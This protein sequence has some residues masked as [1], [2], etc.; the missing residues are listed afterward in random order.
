MKTA[1]VI[2]EQKLRKNL[3]L[4]QY[5]RKEA[6]V[7][8]LVALK[9]MAFWHYFPLMK[10]YLSGACASSLNEV[11]LIYEEMGEK[12]HTYCPVFH[13]EEFEEICR[14]SS[15]I[16]FNSLSQWEKYK[17]RVPEGLSLGLRINPGYSEVE[18]DLYNPARPGSRLGIIAEQLPETLPDGIKGLHFHVLCEQDS[19][20]LERVLKVVEE[21]F[22]EH[23]KQVKWINMGGGHHITRSDYDVE[24]LI[25][26]LKDFKTRYPHLQVVLE[27]GEAVGWQTGYLQCKIEDIVENKG[28][29]IAMLDVSFSA[30][31]PDTLEMPYKPEIRGAGE[32]G[33]KK[34]NYRMGGSS[35]LAGD[36]YGDYSFDHELSAGD[37][38]IFEDMIHY[39]MVKTTM[40]NGVKHPAIAKIDMDGNFLV[41]REIGYDE[42]KYRLS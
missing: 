1:F 23:L 22:S 4:L 20:V 17:D 34:F 10:Q 5:V 18:T 32:P 3:E 16:S 36:V 24:H 30:H 15:H 25:S 27:P 26:L 21:K 33:E 14:M 9:G 28:V 31:M 41:L 29:R 42:Y 7:D 40:F 11:R 39:T 19:Y 37:T 38:I 2:E 35:C 6:N 8:I 12:A 13:E